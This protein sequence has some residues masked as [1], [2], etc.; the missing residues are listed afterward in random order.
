MSDDP[1]QDLPAGPGSAGPRTRSQTPDAGQTAA[2]PQQQD[3]GS[4]L[5]VAVPVEHRPSWLWLVPAAALCFALW[6]VWQVWRD[7]G[8]IVTVSFAQGHGIVAGDAVKFRGIEVGQVRDVTLNPQADAVLVRIAL[9]PDA[10]ELAREG[11]RFWLVRPEFGLQRV[12]GL[13][14]LIGARYIALSPGG[15]E[16]ARTFT[17]LDA[18]PV[19]GDRRPGDLQIIIQCARRGSLSPGSPVTF[20]QV[21]VG[22]VESV[23]L[24]EDATHVE[25]RAVV[26]APYAHL[27]RDNSM[28]W[29]SGGIEIGVGLRG[30]T[31]AVESP[32]ALIRGGVSFATPNDAGAPVA[33]GHRFDLADKLEDSWLKWKPA[34]QRR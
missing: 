2:A 15:G 33:S 30:L 5:P 20:R 1:T 4:G 11:T 25:A 12:S 17:G 24:S 7:R 9:R 8:T 27:V 3:P 13:E 26:E 31:A 6:I 21:Q 10:A 19:V 23:A 28:F 18:P 22:V 34:L 29:D 16:P 32:A 14:T